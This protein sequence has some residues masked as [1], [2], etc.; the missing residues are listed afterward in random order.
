VSVCLSVCLPVTW[1]CLLQSVQRTGSAL[2]GWT[3]LRQK[4]GGSK[5]FVCTRRQTMALGLIVL[6]VRRVLEALSTHPK[7]FECRSDNS[8]PIPPSSQG[9]AE[10]CEGKIWSIFFTSLCIMQDV[11]V[12]VCVC[13][14][15]NNVAQIMDFVNKV[16]KFLVLWNSWNFF[17]GWAAKGFSRVTDSSNFAFPLS[18]VSSRKRDLMSKCNHTKKKFAKMQ[19]T[20]HLLPIKL[21][22][23]C[24]TNQLDALFILSLLPHLSTIFVAHHEEVYCIRVS[25]EERT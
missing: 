11:C 6:S 23:V 12:C 18:H 21:Q 13:V 9:A 17:V 22:G 14:C 24:N 3:N 8:N 10:L 20:K 25:Q 5:W 15:Y 19:K 16:I 1:H 2:R 4:Q 7:R